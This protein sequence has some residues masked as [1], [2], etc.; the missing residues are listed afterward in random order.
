MSRRADMPRPELLVRRTQGLAMFSMTARSRIHD[1]RRGHD[2]DWSST[3]DDSV[4]RT[5]F[6]SFGQNSASVGVVSV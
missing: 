1:K 2:Q 3:R 6:S 4:L 5:R